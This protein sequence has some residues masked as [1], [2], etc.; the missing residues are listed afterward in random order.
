[1]IVHQPGGQ[2]EQFDDTVYLVEFLM[3]TGWQSEIKLP[4]P[5]TDHSA[6]T[7]R[8]LQD[9]RVKRDHEG[10]RERTDKIIA[11][12]FDYIGPYENLCEF[13]AYS[14]SLTSG[15]VRTVELRAHSEKS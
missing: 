3:R 8:E 9:L 5:P 11:E 4:D 10:R 2:D 13:D 14:H 1:M 15:L 6:E 7:Q 12:I